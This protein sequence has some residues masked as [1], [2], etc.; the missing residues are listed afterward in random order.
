M[1]E[2]AQ[3]G[4]LGR[5]L[6]VLAEQDG[7]GK[8]VAR[9]TTAATA[10]E[11]D[12][13]PVPPGSMAARSARRADLGAGTGRTRPDGCRRRRAASTTPA[14]AAPVAVG[15]AG[16]RAAAGRLGRRSAVGFGGRL[17]GPAGRRVG[18]RGRPVRRARRA[19]VGRAGV[20][21][22]GARA[23]P[24]RGARRLTATTPGGQR[25]AAPE[26]GRLAQLLL[27]AQQLVVLGHPVGAGR[28]ARS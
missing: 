4:R 2:L 6:V 3:L 21:R 25:G 23:S 7:S 10:A 28:G 18:G 12:R 24:W 27:D 1:L 16:G 26:G 15:V 8:L 22:R 14:W 5:Q 19:A 11:H 13:D 17:G 20:G 9:M